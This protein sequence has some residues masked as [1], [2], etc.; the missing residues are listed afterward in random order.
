M[1]MKPTIVTIMVKGTKTPTSNAMD[2]MVSVMIIAFFLFFIRSTILYPLN[3]PLTADF[4]FV[5]PFICLIT[6]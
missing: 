5:D 1:T 3:L 6:V 4:E 2:E